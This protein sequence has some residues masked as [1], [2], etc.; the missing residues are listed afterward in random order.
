MKTLLRVWTLTLDLV[1]LVLLLAA[2]VQAQQQSTN[3]RAPRRPERQPYLQD[4]ARADFM[5]ANHAYVRVQ[6]PR[7]RR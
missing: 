2:P 3:E 4:D 5:T 6:E 7:A 1:M